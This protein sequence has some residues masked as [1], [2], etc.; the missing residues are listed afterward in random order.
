[1][2]ALY[3]LADLARATVRTG[4]R[5]VLWTAEEVDRR[6]PQKKACDS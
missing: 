6:M 1:M 3:Q 2:R 5:V 4:I